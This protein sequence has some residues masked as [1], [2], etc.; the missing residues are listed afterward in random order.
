MEQWIIFKN[1]IKRNKIVSKYNALFSGAI[2]TPKFLLDRSTKDQFYQASISFVKV[3]FTTIN[4]NDVKVIWAASGGYAATEVLSV[5]N[6]E[7]MGK[8]KQNPKWFV[9]YSDVCLL[10]NLSLIHI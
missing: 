7:T 4:D 3:P 2:T 6:K 1:Y 8:L 10:L 5:F 9:G